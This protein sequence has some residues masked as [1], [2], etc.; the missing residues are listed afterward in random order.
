MKT[1]YNVNMQNKQPYKLNQM[2]DCINK[3]VNVNLDLKQTMS[4]YENMKTKYLGKSTLDSFLAAI[5]EIDASKELGDCC[6]RG[7]IFF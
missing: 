5:N 6:A 4:F 7:L 3:S 2:L 1:N